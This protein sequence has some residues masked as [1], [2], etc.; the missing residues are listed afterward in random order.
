MLSGN[1]IVIPIVSGTTYSFR[2]GD[3][4]TVKVKLTGA[5]SGQMTLTNG[6]KTGGSIDTLS[7]SGTNSASQLKITAAGGSDDKSTIHDLT[8]GQAPVNAQILQQFTGSGINV[9]TGGTFQ[10][11]GSVGGISIQTVGNG[12]SVNVTGGVVGQFIAQKFDVNSSVNVGGALAS[13]NVQTIDAGAEVVAGTLAKLSVGQSM[14]GASISVEG[15][16]IQSAFFQ[17]LVN[18]KVWTAGVI[19]S[20][21][22]NGDS[23]GSAIAANRHPGS[24]GVFD[25]IDD[26]TIAPNAAGTIGLVKI[27]HYAGAGDLLLIATGAIGSVQSP[28]GKPQPVAV[29]EAVTSFVP[30]EIAQAVADATG[31]DD[32]EIWIAVYGEDLA[33]SALTGTTYY[34]D[35]ANLTPLGSGLYTPTL[36]STSTLTV[37]PSTP[38]LAILPSST[39]ADWKNASSAW[40]S[41]LQLPVPGDNHQFTGR[42]IISVGTPVQAQ[43]N[44]DG[45]VAAP[46]PSDT[47]DPSTGTL[48]DFL[49]FTVTNASGTP[50]LDIDTSQVDSF[51]LPMTLE[52]FSDVLAQD[53]IEI[54]FTGT[55]TNGSKTITGISSMAGLVVGQA[56]GGTGIPAGAIIDSVGSSS[57][58]L[59][60]AAGPA[61]TGTPATFAAL[62]GGPVGVDGRR[63]Q[64]L[65]GDSADSFEKFL[66]NQVANNPG[67]RPFLQSALPFV[68]AGPVPINGASA[69]GNLIVYTDSTA[70]LNN[71]DWVTISGVQGTTAANGSFQVSNITANSFQLVGA[72]SN[73]TYVAGGA[74]SFAVTGAT[75]PGANQPI[76]MSASNVGDLQ[77][78][79][80]VELTGV[81]GN[82]NA[83]GFFQVSNVTPTSFTL[84]D[85][86][87][88][89]GAYTWG[90]TW[91]VYGSGPRLVSPKD[92]VETIDNYASVNE[93]NNYFNEAI[94]DFFLYYLPNTETNL[95]GTAGGGNTF[96]I[97]S[98]ASGS[99]QTYSGVVQNIAGVGYGLYLTSSWSATP[100]VILY[101]FM[102]TNIPTDYAP[103]F[104]PAAPQGSMSDKVAAQSAS[105]MIFAC[106]GVFADN[107]D[108]AKANSLSSDWSKALGDLENSISA[109]FNRGISLVSPSNWGER[110]NWFQQGGQDGKYNYWVEYWHNSGLAVNDLAY[111]FP[112]DDK[113]GSS[114]NL[115]ANNVGLARVLLNTW[116]N[117]QTATAT[118]FQNFPTSVQAAGPITLTAAVTPL[119]PNAPTGTITFFIDGVPINT[120]DFSSNPPQQPIVVNGSGVATITATLPALPD[121]D[122]TH[123][124][125][126]I[127]L[128]SGDALT[129]PSVA[130][131]MLEVIGNS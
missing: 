105:R 50:N 39:L 66:T 131:Q 60:L 88:A 125:T 17:K 116:S 91:R 126:V 22:I 104:Q 89:G 41:N 73:G 18:S 75:N 44:S 32:D 100:F 70:N 107:A 43:V 119:T 82:E 51:G 122:S 101:P 6:L 19:E 53:P 35:A 76:V 69:S 112:Y 36:T 109:A 83:N 97:T 77:D 64:I 45:S 42:I 68:T 27:N 114:T 115:S 106:D 127:A 121:G 28:A 90:G 124:Y 55:A 110:S 86:D 11:N 30:F 129:A 63:N 15:G 123:T 118:A 9:A 47:G 33:P 93:L 20:V 95:D 52:L 113:F 74:W 81:H 84:V 99:L 102:T 57:I 37:G 46:S 1:P 5:G 4:T 61:A 80:Y 38:N 56:I 87:G 8:V 16:T 40:G 128:Y 111:A 62:T 3:G 108:R 71:G 120:N 26:Y 31:F 25:T 130:S 54:S 79:D 98:T 58:T 34:L 94:D 103:K 85:S 21:T 67:A 12:A 2:D 29:D 7:L 92:V 78:G 96:T 13:L 49:E 65:N 14:S 23:A 24:D 117:S 72:T 48:Y 59:S 10:F